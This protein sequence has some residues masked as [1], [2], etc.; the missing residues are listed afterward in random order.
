MPPGCWPPA[1]P[2][3]LAP[4]TAEVEL[5]QTRELADAVGLLARASRAPL[6]QEQPAWT[7]DLCPARNG[8][9]AIFGGERMPHDTSLS[10]ASF[11]SGCYNLAPRS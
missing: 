10:R 3:A 5:E 8:N 1:W 11:M 4:S 6:R 2:R 9:T 7:A